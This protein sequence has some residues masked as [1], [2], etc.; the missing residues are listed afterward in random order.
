MFIVDAQVHIW[1]ANSAERP[2][3]SKPA[4]HRDT[5]LTAGEL[6]HEM[7]G[8]GVSRAVLI[9]PGF[10]GLRNDLILAAAQQYPDRF[11]AVGRLDADA[12]NARERIAT[13][14]DQ[15]GMKGMRFTFTKG[16]GP[17]LAD[18]RLEWVWAEAEKAGV[19]IMMLVPHEM[20]HLVDGI[21]ARY[22]TLKLTMSHLGLETDTRDDEA[23][24]LFDNLFPLAKRPNVMVT[25]SALPTYTSDAY[26][27]RRLHTH[28]RRVYDAFGPERMFWGTDFSRLTCSYQEAINLFTEELPWLSNQDKET[29]MGRG[30]CRWLG[31]DVPGIK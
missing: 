29:I 7:D 31:W 15:P 2:W 19:P 3:V 10:D 30:L 12:A 21:A 22:P 23:F 14:R 20:M 27:F 5:P 17:A 28:I 25:A 26:P 11:C 13:W 18:G 6:L 16:L 9:P 24:R 4:A 8:A 1:A